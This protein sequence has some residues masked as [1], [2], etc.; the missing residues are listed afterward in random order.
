MWIAGPLFLFFCSPLAWGAPSSVA[1][2]SVAS[3]SSVSSP[4]LPRIFAGLTA[5][6]AD[7][8]GTNDVKG[9]Q[10]RGL[11]LGL[12]AEAFRFELSYTQ[13][14]YA[15]T[16]SRCSQGFCSDPVDLALDQR[17]LSA[18]AKYLFMS[19][20]PRPFAGAAL[21]YIRRNYQ[22]KNTV[23]VDKG[24]GSRPAGPLPPSWAVDL[25]LNV[26]ALATL[27]P[28]FE[29]TAQVSYF[30][31]LMGRRE[32]D[33]AVEGYSGRLFDGS[34]ALEDLNYYIFNVGLQYLF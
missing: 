30:L 1:P 23:Y 29:V 12:A 31:K 14:L 7:Y 2:S 13:S 18:G 6:V 22:N 26:G 19:G 15:V 8:A 9:E 28:R 34:A 21:G 33:P 32:G 25:G 16:E 17:N 27:S 4:S 5:G 20:S 10:A 3:S 11:V 24:L